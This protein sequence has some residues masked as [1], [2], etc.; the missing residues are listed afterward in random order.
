MLPLKK[1]RLRRTQHVPTFKETLLRV[2][3]LKQGYRK[4]GMLR[5][6]LVLPISPK[7]S[8]QDVI[9]GL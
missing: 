1:T 8:I 7:I 3:F 2:I 9:A 6:A 5:F 4:K